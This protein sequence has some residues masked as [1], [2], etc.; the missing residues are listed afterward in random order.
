MET[1]VESKEINRKVWF[2]KISKPCILSVIQGTLLKWQI[3]HLPSKML[4]FIK[5]PPSKNSDD[6]FDFETT[7]YKLT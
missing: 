7:E 5:C 6:Q 3:L 1:D 2:K 4:Q